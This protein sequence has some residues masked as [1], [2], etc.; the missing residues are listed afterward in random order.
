[1]VLAV[2]LW[3]A[4]CSGDD[5]GAA[6][7]PKQPDKRTAPEPSADVSMVSAE[8]TV[9]A[10]E[11]VLRVKNGSYL[12]AVLPGIYRERC[13]DDDGDEQQCRFLRT[14]LVVEITMALEEIERSRDQ[15]GAD[16]ALKA[17][18]L[19]D[20]P[21]VLI[22]ALRILGQFP[23]TSGIAEKALPLMLESPWLMVQQLSARVLGQNPDPELAGVGSLWGGNH[24]ALYAEDEYSEYP[25]FA[26]HYFDM[27]FPEYPDAEW[28]S[29][30][31]SDRSVGW[32]TTDDVAAVIDWMRDA[33]DAEPQNFQQWAE[34][35]QEQSMAAYQALDQSK[36]D[37]VQQLTEEYMKTQNLALLEQAQKLQEEL[38]APVQNAG[39]VAEMGVTGVALPSI[40]GVYDEARFFVAEEKDG[41][42]ARAIIVYALAGL[43][44]TVIQEAWNLVD[45]PSAWPA[46]EPEAQQE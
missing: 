3:I 41:H 11:F 39:K 27:Q 10:G 40:A 37:R 9:D 23:D 2:T 25:D 29:P 46:A 4:A 12:S 19:D 45:Y 35:L 38:Y 42:V 20:E 8:A 16:E 21:A 28:F 34:Y 14:L 26:A 18:D 15:R 22:A 17:L 6:P 33:L 13:I 30:A 1:M 36:L 7:S 32:A 24:G 43:G 31:D 5:E 44:R